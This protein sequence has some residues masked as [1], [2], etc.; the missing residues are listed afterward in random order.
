MRD[1]RV[2]VGRASRP[3]WTWL[4]TLGLLMIGLAPFLMLAA[5]LVWGLDVGDD[6]AFLV[7]LIVVPWVGALLVWRSGTWSKVVAIVIALAGAGAMFWT[8]F[9][10]A[11][12]A[13]FFDF[14]PGLLVIPGA[15]TAIVGSVAAIV[16]ARRGHMSTARE[17]GERRATAAIVGAVGVL[18][19]LSGVLTV[20]SRTT[21]DTTDAALTVH[22]ADFEYEQDAYSVAGGST[23]AVRNDDPFLHTFTIDA[24]GIDLTLGPRSSETVEIPAEAG[25]Y[26]VYCR[27][28]TATPDSPGESDM[29][30]QLTV[31]SS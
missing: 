13:S 7:S 20:T 14:V 15:V 30:A 11:E 19:V 27:P 18:A 21:V 16:A 10:L 3:R 2:A 24:L 9:G 29:A 12:P 5:A 23:V 25:T 28:H 8:A 4:A 26:V 31:A 22:L 6:V 1:D 17:G